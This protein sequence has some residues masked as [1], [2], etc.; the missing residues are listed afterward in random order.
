M[1]TRCQIQ[2]IDREGN[3]VTL[4][5]HCDGYP[6]NMIRVISKALEIAGSNED[7]HVQQW[8]AG[9][10]GYAA[11]L[12]CAADLFEFQPEA[13]HELHSDIDY[14]YRLYVS[15]SKSP[16]TGCGVPSWEVEVRTPAEGFSD[17][18]LLRNTVVLFTRQPLDTL[19]AEVEAVLVSDMDSQ[20]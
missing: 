11:G 17:K 3:K 14:L 4:Y 1:S 12:L 9:R 2:V 15:L 18:P 20:A 13:G 7:A 6:A 10:T 16:E 19:L 8:K 5:H